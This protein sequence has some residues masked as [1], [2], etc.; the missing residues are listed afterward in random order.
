MS[1][2]EVINS[3]SKRKIAVI[4]DVML[5]SYIY[6]S[7]D[8]I[9]PEAPVPIVKYER[10]V[11]GLGGAANVAANINSLGGN[12]FLFGYTGEDE[13][14]DNLIA[15]LKEEKINHFL[16]PSFSKTIQKTRIIGNN[17]QIA[18]IDKENGNK[19]SGGE[20]VII[21]KLNEIN[22]D[23]IIISD[24]AKGTITP[25]LFNRLR[26]FD[27]KIIVD[28][29]PENNLDYSG[30]YL[31]TPNLKEGIELS[32]TN[33]P[34]K[35]G[36]ILQKRYNANILLTRGKE[37][38]TI[39]EGEQSINIPTQS[40]EVYDVTGAGDSVIATIGLAL[41][42]G[43]NLTESAFLANQVAG[44]IVGRAGTSSVSK[45][46]L[47]QLIESETNKIKTLNELKIIREDYGRKGKVF[48]WTNGCFDLLHSGH[49]NYLKKARKLGD[50]LAVGLNSDGSIK[51]L[52]GEGRPV[53]GEN[54]RAEVLSSLEYV[55][56]IVIFSELTVAKCLRELKPDVYIKAGDYDINK[57]DR[58]ERRIIENYG[59]RFEFIPITRKISTTEIIDKIKNNMD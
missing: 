1:L 44:V 48:L 39:F 27:K 31:I 20:E 11:Y 41:A 38:M 53:R 43:L 5:D 59:G 14:R 47:E 2:N 54:C 9:S 40:K 4:G 6:G 35:I 42:S 10:E 22:P 46:E 15:K 21:N 7:V 52:K 33:E 25:N 34:D 23:L 50:Y 30:A 55:D 58:E 32:G 51:K 13:A 29:K 8:R 16:L 18:R 24:Y 49:V 17:R 19:I 56:G 37:G 57:M 36:K 3:F 28:P 26:E 12:T 45:Q